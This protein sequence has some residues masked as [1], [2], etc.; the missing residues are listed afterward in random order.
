[1]KYN[2]TESVKMKKSSN[3]KKEKFLKNLNLIYKANKNLLKK[4]KPFLAK[5]KKTIATYKQKKEFNKG[6]L[7]NLDRIH[8]ECDKLFEEDKVLLQELRKEINAQQRRA[9]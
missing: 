1:M 8:K 4:D 5:L 7:K 3:N 9:S 2:I 6:T